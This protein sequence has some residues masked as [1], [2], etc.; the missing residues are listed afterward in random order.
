MDDF[1][2]PRPLGII[3]EVVAQLKHQLDEEADI[4]FRS[5]S[6][7][8]GTFY[9]APYVLPRFL[10][11]KLFALLWKPAV[12]VREHA[13]HEPLHHVPRQNGHLLFANAHTTSSLSCSEKLCSF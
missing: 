10:I 13:V 3:I 8:S 4:P 11:A 9:A 7:L 1:R 12:Q 5:N 6:D 2:S